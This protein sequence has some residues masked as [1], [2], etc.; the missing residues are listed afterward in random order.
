M[1]KHIT[2]ADL[3]TAIRNRGEFRSAY[4]TDTELNTYINVSLAHLYDIIISAD[5]TYY[6]QYD[7]IPIAS[8]TREY[9]LPDDFYKCVGV[10]IKATDLP[11]GYAVLSRYN[12]E[13][14]YDSITADVATDWRYEIRGNSI[15]LHPTPDSTEELR[16]EY[17]PVP[18]NLAADDDVWDSVNLWTE[19]VVL[20]VLIVCA[21]K[22]ET[23]ATAWVQQREK[24]EA[25]IKGIATRDLSEVKTSAT[26]STLKDL[27]NAIRNRG[28]WAR[29]DISDNQLTEWINVAQGALVDLICS[30]DPSYYL[31]EY[32]GVL[33]PNNESYDLPADF[34]KAVAVSC[35]FSLYSG[36][37]PDLFD[38][39]YALQ[40]CT[41]AEYRDR[42]TNT[43]DGPGQA[44]LNT[45]MLRWTIRGPKIYFTPTPGDPWA[46]GYKF[47]LDYIA[48]PTALTDP[49][50]TISFPNNWIEW[51]I[52]ECSVKA[53]TFVGTDPQAYM[54]QQQR[55]EERIAK[56][57]SRDISEDLAPEASVLRIDSIVK[58]I[59]S[60]GNWNRH[61]ITNNEIYGLMGQG[62]LQ[63]HNL[64]AN[65]E[66]RFFYTEDYISVTSDSRYYE[67]PNNFYK[68]LGVSYY[69]ENLTDGYAVMES[70]SWDERFNASY[71]S[72][73][74]NTRY[75]IQGVYIWFEPAPLWEGTV[76]LEYIRLPSVPSV[77]A[78]GSR[79]WRLLFNAYFFG[80]NHA[81][82]QFSESYFWLE[83]II[84][85][86]SS[87]IAVSQKE[88]PTQ[89]LAQRERVEQNIKEFLLSRDISKQKTTA[90]S[91]TLKA[92][93]QSIRGRGKWPREAFTDTQLTEWINSSN[94]ALIDLLCTHDISYF[95]SKEDITVVSGTREYDLPSD[96]YKIQ[97]A[98]VADDSVDGYL[99]LTRV[100]WAERWDE[101][102]SSD[103][104][105]TRYMIRGGKIQ[106]QPTPRWA[107]TVR[108]EYIPIPTAMTAP[109]STF[110]Y[111]ENS[112]QEWVILD[113][114]VK[115]A[116]CA[117]TDPQAYM[118][119]KAQ[120][121]ERII[122][123]AEIDV[124]APKQVVD[125]ARRFSLRRTR[126]PW[127]YRGF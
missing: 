77:N 90:T 106:F 48:K 43:F 51:L 62:L 124:G 87:K 78:F 110:D 6:L 28:K 15:F 1:V 126:Y 121:E 67:L 35:E 7:K 22:E 79:D 74:S 122:A 99:A 29:T 53:A 95:L 9:D 10:A 113:C 36:A 23:D 73:P 58:M 39:Y 82:Q 17:I 30:Y 65:V 119:Q 55:M 3:R 83:Y 26:V 123:N 101:T 31:T 34:Y 116:V 21:A 125:T 117:G 76:R 33:V 20:D 85:D 13:E 89:F 97:G 104:W 49:A 54:V 4:I 64:I 61:T 88:D 71:S 127:S 47:R 86:A 84:A 81:T 118:A 108:L 37:N 40:Q 66:P 42:T 92:L 57:A 5:P 75:A 72:I 27:R 91:G 11:D 2:R 68:L 44:G 120:V 102:W 46:D 100:Q 19:W 32:C 41:W 56:F 114:C 105:D 70:F 14:R 38:G 93:Q 96:F 112:W 109:T 80:D 94:A 12:F 63:L 59:R 18:T 111:Y 103:K 45:T 24:V 69:D 16:L 60:R 98:S 115:A 50:D 25:R 107:G 8:G 52:L